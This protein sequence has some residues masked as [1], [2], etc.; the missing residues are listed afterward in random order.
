VP[1]TG[2]EA[3]K[4]PLPEEVPGIDIEVVV[5]IHEDIGSYY[6]YA[7]HASLSFAWL[8]TSTV[9]CWV[10]STPNSSLSTAR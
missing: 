10:H 4:I 8:R 3:M 1:T 9:F 2:W 7:D 5:S 6:Y